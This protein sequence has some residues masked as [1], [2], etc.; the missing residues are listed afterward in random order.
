[1]TT[2]APAPAHRPGMFLRTLKALWEFLEFSRRLTF[3]LIFL[4]ILLIIMIALVSGGGTPLKD[5]SVLVL[6]P[7]GAIVEQYSAAPFDRALS[8]ALGEDAQE[9]RLR[10]IKQALEAAAEDK[11]IE[12]VLLVPHNITS[13]GAASARDLAAALQKFKESKKQLIAY[14]DFYDQRQMLLAAQADEVYLHPDGAVLLE[15]LGRYRTYFKDAFDKFGIEPHLFR[16]GEFKSAG[17]PYIRSDASP[18]AEEADL[19]WMNDLWTRHLNELA[20]ARKLSPSDL[21]AGIDDLP[22]RVAAHGGDLAKF[23]LEEKLVDGLK[24]RD[25]LEALLIERG[26]KDEDGKTYEHI[27]LK[28]YLVLKNAMPKFPSDEQV[29]VVVAEGEIVDGNASGGTVGGDATSELIRQARLD[30]NVKALVL[31][32]NSPGGGV[33]PSELIRREVELTKKAGKPVVVSMGNLAASGGYWISMNADRIFA[34]ESTITG[35]IGIFGLFFNVPEAMSKV[36]LN[37]DG[38]GTTWLAGAFDP[39]RPLD[40]RVGELIQTVINKGYADFIGKVAQARGQKVEDIDRIARGRVWSGAQAKEFGLVDEL[41]GFDAAL[42]HAAKL[43]KL[44]DE[45][46]TK[47]EEKAMSPF[48]QMMVDMGGSRLTRVLNARSLFLPLIGDMDQ[49]KAEIERIERLMQ[50]RHAGLPFSVQAHCNCEMR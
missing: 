22:A 46:Q 28:P 23:A 11:H 27:D 40:P 48:E 9:T 42:A 3:N 36:G 39:T 18:E 24:T 32:V 31:R 7:K 5:R 43:A 41:G 44:G 4:L 29:A 49:R 2:Q 15:G 14:G 12:R 19:H 33:F 6:A 10:D 38:V 1:M 34:D 17:E 16:V 21:Q 37:T 26:V 50:Q 47:Y 45:F 20:T 35:S 13:I 8:E 30:E 25:E